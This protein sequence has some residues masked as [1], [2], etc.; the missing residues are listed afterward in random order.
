[1]LVL[2]KVLATK[3]DSLLTPPSQIEQVTTYLKTYEKDFAEN[4]KHAL[5][6]LHLGGRDKEYVSVV[7][8]Y[9]QSAHKLLTPVSIWMILYPTGHTAHTAV[10]GKI[11]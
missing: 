11:K 8:T 6:K 4:A 2:L 10:L 7:E 1:M 5:S 3:A 9:A